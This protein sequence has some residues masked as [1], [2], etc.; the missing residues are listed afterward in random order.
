MKK[1]LTEDEAYA[2]EEKIIKEIHLKDRSK[3]YNRSTGGKKSSKGCIISKETRMKLSKVQKERGNG[4]YF[5]GADACDARAVNQYDCNG[6][7]IK[8]WNCIVD[9]STALGIPQY[10]IVKSCRFQRIIGKGFIWLYKEEANRISEKIQAYNEKK[11]F[12]R[13]EVNSNA[14]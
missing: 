8:E 12:M 5:K 6:N 13:K 2:L 7:L 10:N 3:S 14:V 9:A 11:V 1:D 4:G